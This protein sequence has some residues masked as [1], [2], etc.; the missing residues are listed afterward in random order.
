[1]TGLIAAVRPTWRDITAHPLRIVAAVL[2]IA[3]PVGLISG[4]VVT[5]HS[6]SQAEQLSDPRTII[7]AVGG[8]CEQSVQGFSYS[9]SEP[10]GDQT[11]AHAAL[12]ATL[13]P[14]FQAFDIYR[15]SAHVQAGEQQGYVNF[16]QL[17]PELAR[18]TLGQIDLQPDHILLTKQEADALEA[19]EGD[20]I[21]V[22]GRDGDS[23]SLTVA[24]IKPGWESIVLSPAIA[25]VGDRQ[26]DDSGQTEWIV[27]GNRPMTWDDV[28][29]LNAQGFVVHSQDVQD[30][31]PPPE[32]VPAEFRDD[33]YSPDAWF[34]WLYAGVAVVNIATVLLLLLAIVSPVFSIAVSRQSRNY[35]LMASQGA[36]GRHIR[37]AVLAYGTISGLIG[38]TLGSIAGVAIAGGI[39]VS[40]FPQWSVV[41]PWGWLVL[42][43]LAG[44]VAAT[45]S[46]F[47]PAVLASRT[48]I[49]AGMAG[50][51]PDR[52]LRWRGWMAA[53]PIGLFVLGL[54]WLLGPYLL[55]ATWVTAFDAFAPVV[56]LLALVFLLAC[57]PAAVY[58]ASLVTD[59]MPLAWRLA[60]RDGRRQGLKT[61][62][63]VA[64][65]MVI[66]FI[67]TML[68]TAHQA[69]IG[70]RNDAYATMHD[71]TAVWVHPH[72]NLPSEDYTEPSRDDYAD[73]ID[74]ARAM[75]NPVSEVDL[76]AIDPYTSIWLDLH[77]ECPV[78]S[79]ED[80]PVRLEHLTDEQ[81]ALCA[82]Y[83]DYSLAAPLLDTSSALIATPGLLDS[84][85]WPQGS[86]RAAADAV[87]ANN[88]PVVLM[89]DRLGNRP[90]DQRLEIGQ[91][92]DLTEVD[93][94]VAPV[95][96]SNY[97]GPLIITEALAERIGLDIGYGG[98]LFH[99]A[100]VLSHS[101]QQKVENSEAVVNNFMEVSFNYDASFGPRE[102]VIASG[103]I[104]LVILVVIGLVL[105]LSAPLQRT[106]L[107]VY[108]ALGAAP[109]VSG[110][111]SAAYATFM[112]LI[113]GGGGWVL[114]TLA[115]WLGSLP[116]SNDPYGY[117]GDYG[118][119]IAPSW[120]LGLTV[121][122]VVPLL[123]AAVGWIMHRG[124]P[125]T[126]SYRET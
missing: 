98:T 46:A 102:G 82:Y 120:E 40:T 110:R 43:W 23:V 25:T 88:E 74:A 119:Y 79:D 42:T 17:H 75:L 124:T 84:L 56:M 26:F 19:S 92:E 11:T 121:I 39:W 115:A 52:M 96:P 16:V 118:A 117:Y 21:T 77:P 97:N 9:C 69:N 2:L 7:T 61:V 71:P 44:V 12:D 91:Q 14:G 70:Q 123:A 87:V 10:S 64:A 53:G 49:T 35:A 106:R 83:F 45:V 105:M 5:A 112:A 126:P 95:L 90:L 104:G 1:M 30:N 15:D 32:A 51:V 86:D 33:V 3:L 114:G 122:V 100:E 57:A 31:P 89:P 103:V 108:A 65:V 101:E 18:G 48:A 109:G 73:G 47:L 94:R 4:L 78:L 72:P 54:V 22:T 8:T 107:G 116:L 29:E 113:A 58:A 13:P 59:R 76:L 60:G 55:P 27:T 36:S 38:A 111:I 37:T 85:V 63:T 81:Q 20:H 67:A 80:D 62:P 34:W 28:L 66:V 41:F 68:F 6:E 24:G 125:L 99:T 50:G 93:V